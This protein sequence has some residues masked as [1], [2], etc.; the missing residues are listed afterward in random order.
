MKNV[1]V[2]VELSVALSLAFFS[3]AVLAEGVVHVV[4]IPHGTDRFAPEIVTISKGDTVRWVN[5]DSAQPS[6]DF[7]SV[8]GPKRENK[9]LK[10]IELRAGQAT[11]HAFNIPGSYDYFCYIHRGMVG[12]VIVTE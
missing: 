1:M 9:E 2:A 8:P 7:A 10:V 5:N 12:R 6:H 4:E 3:A 11:E